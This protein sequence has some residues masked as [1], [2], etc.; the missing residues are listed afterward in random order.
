MENGK[1]SQE[2]AVDTR[3]RL[4]LIAMWSNNLHREC[5]D[6]YQELVEIYDSGE[7]CTLSGT[8]RCEVCIL[9]QAIVELRD[10]W[11]RINQEMSHPVNI[12][13]A[14]EQLIDWIE[15]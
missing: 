12:G 14:I 4:R 3:K 6:V 9:M 11:S 2:R 13:G 10:H 5:R 15:R 8:E 1:V 7:C